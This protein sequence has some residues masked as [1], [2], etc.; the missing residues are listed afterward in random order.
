MARA[1]IGPSRPQGMQAKQWAKWTPHARRVFTEVWNIMQGN[2]RLFMHPKQEAAGMPDQAHWNTT[3]W[4]AA[5]TAA[6]AVDKT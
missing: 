3:C 6:D 2:C 1:T 5:W 4:N